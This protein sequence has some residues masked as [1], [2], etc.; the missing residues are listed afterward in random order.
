MCGHHFEHCVSWYTTSNYIVV[1]EPWQSFL[2]ECLITH[3]KHEPEISPNNNCLIW[4]TSFIV[5]VFHTLRP[6]MPFCV[7]C[8]LVV[9]KYFEGVLVQTCTLK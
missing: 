4:L 2:H 7:F 5:E 1:G 9:S 3:D 6:Q 8:V